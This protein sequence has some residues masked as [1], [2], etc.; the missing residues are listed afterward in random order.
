M[1]KALRSLELGYDGFDAQLT[2]PLTDA[3]TEKLSYELRWPGPDRICTSPM[4]S[5]PVGRCSISSTPT[6]IDPW[7]L[8]QIEI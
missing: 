4:H 8:A 5:V 7:F 2:L 6:K 1:Q 3:A